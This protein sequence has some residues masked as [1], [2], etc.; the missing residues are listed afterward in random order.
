[1]RFFL[2]GFAIL[3]SA[4]RRGVAKLL[5]VPGL[6]VA[7]AG[8]GG[9]D[10]KKQ[11]KGKDPAP[12]D[13]RFHVQTKASKFAGPVPLQIK[14][15][16]IPFKEDGDVEY[17]WRFDD[18]TTSNAQNP[19][20]TFKKPGYYQVLMDARDEQSNTRWNLFVGAWGAVEWEKAQKRPRPL[21]KKEAAKV[22]RRQWKRTHDRRAIQKQAA[23]E[24]TKNL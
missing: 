5:I 16:V 22:R 19:V 4:M 24:R 15:N 17:R 18:G 11:A 23:L 3:A 10:D 20:H 7:I 13:T 6:A 9:D 12:N 8:C 21:T 2:A 1:V 14:F